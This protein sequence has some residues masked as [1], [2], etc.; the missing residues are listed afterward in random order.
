M[1]DR[2]KIMTR[3]PARSKIIVEL[4]WTHSGINKTYTTAWQLY[5]WPHMKNDIEQAMAACSLC[6]AN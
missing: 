4:H 6:Q 3:K 2:A 5:Y 1:K